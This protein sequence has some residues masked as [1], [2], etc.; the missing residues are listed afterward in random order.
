MGKLELKED[1]TKKGIQSEGWLKMNKVKILKED[2]RY[3]IFYSF[4]Q[5]EVR[6]KCQNSDGTRCSK[7][8]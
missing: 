7:N 1:V 3:V 8:G 2:G 6:E 5:E 4:P